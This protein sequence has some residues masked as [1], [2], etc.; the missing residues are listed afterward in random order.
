MG[1]D[2]TGYQVDH[3][4]EVYVDPAIGFAG[5]D[6]RQELE[7]LATEGPS[8][9]Y[10][11]FPTYEGLAIQVRIDGP[12]PNDAK[13]VVVDY[14]NNIEGG[15]RLIINEIEER[16]RE[17]GARDARVIAMRRGT[18]GQDRELINARRVQQVTN[19]EL[20]DDRTQW[21]TKEGWIT[22]CQ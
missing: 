6:L 12:I 19:I 20:G 4:A 21:Y 17:Q 5:D 10:V 14:V 9:V 8:R 2:T 16:V 11:T 3:P 13:R 15:G 7:A 22:L 18:V 1:D